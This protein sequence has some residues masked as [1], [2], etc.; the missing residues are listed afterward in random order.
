MSLTVTLLVLLAA[1]LHA[2]WNAVV[3]SGADRLS[4]MAYVTAGGTLVMLPLLYFTPFPSPAMWSVIGLSLIIH[5]GYKLFLIK[6]YSHGSL[7]Q[8]YPLARGLAP[9]IVTLVG[10][11]FLDE[12]LATHAFA[13]IGIIIL[14]ILSLA[15]PRRGEAFN[16]H[17]VFYAIATSFFIAAYT[18]NDGLG[19]RMEQG[20]NVYAIWLMALDGVLLWM[21]AIWR[22]PVADLLRPSRAM[23]T[24][25]AG[26]VLSVIA[27][28][29]VI[30]AMSISPMGPVATLRET[31]VVF[32]A[33]ISGMI[34]KEGLGARAVLAAIAVAAGVL[35][36]KF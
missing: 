18:L 30:W 26:G 3:K 20:P 16:H 34:L 17:G 36:L 15:I 13:G 10:F 19:G 14:G 9:A 6:A 33:L 27:Y 31:S 25:A 5:L 21:V 32:A 1:L 23:V 28:W 29:I 2:I 35:V 24:G 22:R 4:T 7:G 12:D 8:V 11:I